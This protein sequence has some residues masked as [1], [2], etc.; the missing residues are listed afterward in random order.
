MKQLFLQV[1]IIFIGFFCSVFFGI[2]QTVDNKIQLK[3]EETDSIEKPTTLA[4]NNYKELTYYLSKK[5]NE[6]QEEGFFNSKFSTPLKVNDSTFITKL[7]KNNKNTFIYLRNYSELPSIA[8]EHFWG[9]KK[10]KHISIPIRELKSNLKQLNDKLSSEGNPFNS[11]TLK[12]IS[13]KEDS[14]FADLNIQNL[15]KRTLDSIVIKGYPKFPISF[16]RHYAGIKKGSLYKDSNIKNQSELINNLSFVKTIKPSEILFNPKKTKLF[17]YIKKQ[18]AN[19]FDGFLGFSTE[20][21]SGNVILDGYLNLN[22][23]NNLNFG[24][25]LHLTY[26]SDSDK[27]Q[28]FNINTKLPYIF[29]LPLTLEGELS[30]FRQEDEFSSTEQSIG[31]NYSF[32]PKIEVLIGYKT[33]ESADLN[34]NENI[35]SLNTNFDSKFIQTELR[36]LNRQNELLFPKK[37]NIIL[38]SEIGSRSLNNTK[39]YKIGIEANHIFKLNTRN[40]IYISNNT[41]YFSSNDFLANELYRLGGILSIRGFEENSL[42]AN[43]F[44][45]LNTEYRYQLSTNIY[46][47]T[48]LDFAY[49]N[50]KLLNSSEQLTSIGFGIGILTKAGVFKLN[51][52][53]GK[54][55][56]N[57]F[58]FGNSKI[59]ISLTAFF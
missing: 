31:L 28:Q 12:N 10:N 54:N 35:V 40:S 2:S 13:Q 43:I 20:E 58:E 48:I 36:Y 56:D 3:I 51:Y 17:I 47:H 50:N 26:K 25:E 24:E 8:K 57:P 59:H 11:L 53:N 30:I 45:V 46:A 4:F 9:F 29:K 1:N 6:L 32:N 39:Q 55:R 15:R 27:Q 33:Y 23:I 37:T 22:L 52:A 14:I 16:I 44:N 41:Q 5:T 21:D 49:L 19:N 38:S 42:R 7:T 18:N 34:E